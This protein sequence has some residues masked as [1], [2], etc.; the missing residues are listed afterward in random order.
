MKTSDRI[1]KNQVQREFDRSEPDPQSL[2]WDTLLLVAILDTLEE[3]RDGSSILGVGTTDPLD[4]M[5]ERLVSLHEGDVRRLNWFSADINRLQDVY[6]RIQNE[7]EDLRKAI[8]AL[9][10]KS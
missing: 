8:D 4:A 2:G 10:E 6:W 9:M 7:D 1:L 5:K 3:I